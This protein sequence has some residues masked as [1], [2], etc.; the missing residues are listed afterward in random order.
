MRK[1]K[2]V[3]K[4]EIK[5]SCAMLL[6]QLPDDRQDF[7]LAQK[8]SNLLYTLDEISNWLRSNTKH[9]VG[10]EIIEEVKA[11]MKENEIA[12]KD[13]AML[14]TLVEIVLYKVRDKIGDLRERY[15]GFEP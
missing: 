11:S 15:G 7:L 1:R 6:Y 8:A 4:V 2:P 13:E 12:I 9:G 3:S 5:S 10:S 14:R